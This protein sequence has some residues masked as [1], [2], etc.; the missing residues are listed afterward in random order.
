MCLRES[1][2]KRFSKHYPLLRSKDISWSVDLANLTLCLEWTVH[3]GG[4]KSR[5][6]QLPSMAL[7]ASSVSLSSP[8]A[9]PEQCKEPIPHSFSLIW[10]VYKP[11]QK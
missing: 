10:F 1:P 3:D 7:L 8:S 11:Q 5:L 9:A 4:R 6:G 2:G